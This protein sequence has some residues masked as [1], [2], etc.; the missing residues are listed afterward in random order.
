[1]H[2]SLI[3]LCLALDALQLN[4]QAYQRGEPVDV[5]QFMTRRNEV[6]K[7]A[8]AARPMLECLKATQ[9]KTVTTKAIDMARG[10]ADRARMEVVA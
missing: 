3:K 4:E 6:I 7:T 2:L 9:P 5:D 1:M 10:C 8:K